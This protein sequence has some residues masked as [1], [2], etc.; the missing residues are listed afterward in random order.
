MGLYIAGRWE[1]PALD[2]FA[3]RLEAA[4]EACGESADITARLLNA[5]DREAPPGEEGFI[6]KNRGGRIDVLGQDVPGLC[7]GMDETVRHLADG[8]GLSALRE[9]SQAPCFR[10]RAVKFN[11]PWSCYRS[12]RSVTLHTKTVR[13]LAFWDAFLDMMAEHRFNVLTLWSVH[14]YPYMTRARSYPLACEM[15]DEELEAW[16]AFW[17]GLF[18]R[19]KARCIRPFIM[20]MNVHVSEGFRKHY[21]NRADTDA[22]HW[23]MAHL[24][25]DVERYLRESVTQIIDEYPDLAGIGTSLG[26][27]MDGMTPQERE[28]FHDRV[29]GE[30]VRRAGRPVEIIRRA[31]FSAN[32]D[33]QVTRAA[34]EN[35]D[36]SATQPIW[37]EIKYN[38]SHGYSSP[39]L[40]AA[41]GVTWQSTGDAGRVRELLKGYWEPEPKN[42]R[43]ALMVRNEDFFVLR[44]AQ[45]D[46]IR[47]HIA[48]N[49]KSYVGGYFIGSEGL[50]PA[51]DYM[52]APGHP[53][54]SWRYLFEKNRLYYMMW[55]RLLFDPDTPDDVFAHDIEKRHGPGTGVP[56]LLAY[57]HACKMPMALATFH[58]A[59]WD[60][61]LYSEGFLSTRFDA[62]MFTD[63]AFNGYAPGRSFITLEHLMKCVPLD[64]DWLSAR[65]Y[66]EWAV[67]GQAD[68]RPPQALG[69]RVTPLMVADALEADA[70]RAEEALSAVAPG[71]PSL[72][73]EMDDIR[74]WIALSR[75]LAC[76]L[77][78]AAALSIYFLNHDEAKR[79]EA[80]R[81]LDEPHAKAHWNRLVE[82]TRS[83]YQAMP[84]VSLGTEPFHWDLFSP[85]VE[86][87]IRYAQ[88][89]HTR[90]F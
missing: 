3:R 50:I 32:T 10:F 81:W 18:S 90:A 39:K 51:E 59:T 86:A 87:D 29:Y 4:L 70:G 2:R 57:R 20:S 15:G 74:A 76:K 21:D 40:L 44:W 49:R 27:H 41:H 77:R 53:H 8:Y 28:A 65:A 71:G 12:N 47:A 73:C 80:V 52:H 78:A 58:A 23:G 46:F 66:A 64:P 5:G 13:D 63:W 88:G 54:V 68:G 37:L 1:H 22:I 36:I 69:N 85:E 79:E 48:E 16:R 62:R 24:T 30:A 67:Q 26:E 84:L 17:T 89:R 19:C 14:P 72:A 35:A 45:S 75:Y 56:L 43:M 31:P 82:I 11:L 83:H 33:A 42:Y 55:G 7:Y 38:F 60:F 61:S 25:P 9:R 34:I 6:L